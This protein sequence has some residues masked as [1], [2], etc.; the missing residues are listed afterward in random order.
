MGKDEGVA[1][2][3]TGERGIEGGGGTRGMELKEE[4]ER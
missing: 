4:R 3:V 2:N 1:R